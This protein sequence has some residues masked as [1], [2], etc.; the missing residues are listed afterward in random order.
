MGKL[1]YKFNRWL[2]DNELYKFLFM[3]FVVVLVSNV[4]INIG[5]WSNPIDLTYVI[6]GSLWA[7]FWLLSRVW[8][9][10]GGNRG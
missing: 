6:I 1:N 4:I 7:G 2:D 8:Y 3:L 10:R 5:I 9:L